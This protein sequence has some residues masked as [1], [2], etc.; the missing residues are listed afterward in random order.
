MCIRDRYQRRVHGDLFIWI[1]ESQILAYVDK[2]FDNNA[3]PALMKYITIH[4]LSPGFDPTWETNENAQAA[5]DLLVSW[6]KEQG[7]VGCSVEVVKEPG[8]THLIIVEIEPTKKPAMTVFMYAHWDK[9]PPL[10][11]KWE[12][13]LG[14]FQPVIK[15]G[16]IWGRGS[17][18]DG[19]GTFAAVLSIKACQKLK[20]EHPRI[21]MILES[22]EESGDDLKYYL[23]KLIPSRF[24]DVDAVICLDSGAPVR[25]RF[26]ITS[27]LRGVM[28]F[29][30]KVKVLKDPVH[31]GDAGGIVPESFRI[32]R[33]LLNRLEDV[34]TGAMVAP[35]QVAIPEERKK[36]NRAMCRNCC[37]PCQRKLPKITRCSL[38][39]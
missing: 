16:K 14:P 22:C 11:G 35:F 19:Y 17:A 23:N 12:P 37:S 24:K 30:L 1:M 36:R 20:L 13:G 21:V 39:G 6:I 34:K 18:D 25:D 9:Q 10:E 28:N 7:L 27:A 5:C 31:S 3:L 4:N 32:C 15:D 8:K 29:N 2:E 33:E 38:Y 26:W